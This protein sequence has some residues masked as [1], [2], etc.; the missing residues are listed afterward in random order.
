MRLFTSLDP[1]LLLCFSSRFGH[2]ELAVMNSLELRLVDLFL[3]L[4]GLLLGLLLL[5]PDHRLQNNGSK[6][7]PNTAPLL[8][9]NCMIEPK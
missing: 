1:S 2:Q 6:Y 4:F 8:P 7:R 9:I 3:L 5:L